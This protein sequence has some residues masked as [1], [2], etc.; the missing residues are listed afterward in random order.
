MSTSAEGSAAGI[1]EASV[2][3][4]LVASGVATLHEAAGRR[5][6]CRDLRLLVGPPFAG[7]AATVALPAGDNLG[8]HAALATA[9]RASVLCAASAGDGRFGVI[10]ELIATAARA[11]GVTALVIDDG[12]RDLDAL[13]APPSIAARSVTAQGTIKRRYLSLGGPVG[14]AGV[15]VRPGDWVVG[16]ADGIIVLPAEQI[17]DVVAG[18][19]AR[20]G[21]EDVLRAR[22]SGGESTVDALGLAKLIEKERSKP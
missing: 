4:A 11:R 21:R 7:R 3:S 18:A 13:E 8:V 20:T 2:A 22:L 10:G 12:V 14:L 17:D 16:D 1:P 19:R 5:G 9:P 15:L 6:L